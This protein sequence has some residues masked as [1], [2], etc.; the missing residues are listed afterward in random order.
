MSARRPSVDVVV[1]FQGSAAEL[2]D[3]QNRL[4]RIELR[5]GDSLLVADNT[6]GDARPGTL[7]AP[8]IPTPAYARNRGAAEGSNDWLVFVDADTTPAPDLLDRYF[9][10]SPAERTALLA[11]GIADEPVPP[12]GPAAA[13]YAYVRGFM[14]QDDTLRF[15]NWS[16]PK[17]A[18]AAVRR[19]AFEELGGFREELRAAE[20]ADLTYR[21]KAAG[22]GMERREQA[23]VVH[24]NRRTLRGFVR[25]K[26]D[27]G[28]G[29]AWLQR[30]HPGSSPGRRLPGLLW[31]GARHAVGGLFAAARTR[32]RD[33]A[34]WAVFEP[35]ELIAHELGR[36][37]S[38]ERGASPQPP[39]RAR[40]S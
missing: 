15:G 3:L 10:P 24:H 33:R 7:H 30:A 9:D 37:R 12:D 5:E 21:L 17:T 16:F 14:S 25:Q 4:A 26:L 18:N 36:W 39:D 6:P 11:G 27:H 35:V 28:A 23:S 40:P 13:R 8:E 31:W 19:A 20:D 29:G 38:N 32:D 22:W 1:P 34:L 2:E